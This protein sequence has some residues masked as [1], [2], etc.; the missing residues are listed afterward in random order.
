MCLL[1]KEKKE[2]IGLKEINKEEDV[3]RNR[4]DAKRQT[5]QDL[6]G[7]RSPSHISNSIG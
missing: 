7:L 1:S 2:K 5:E 6:E 4:N 3:E